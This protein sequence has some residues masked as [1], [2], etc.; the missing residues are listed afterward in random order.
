MEAGES[1]GVAVATMVPVPLLAELGDT[2]QHK[3]RPSLKA[4]TDHKSDGFL[5]GRTGVTGVTG[6]SETQYHNIIRILLVIIIIK[7]GCFK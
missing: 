7:C 6:L 3:T 5:T 1:S 2:R 4:W